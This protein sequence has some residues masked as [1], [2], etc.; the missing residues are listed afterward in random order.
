MRIGR[1]RAAVTGDDRRKESLSG[2]G[3]P[4]GR[5]GGRTTRKPEDLP[6]TGLVWLSRS[7]PSGSVWC[8]S[9]DQS[10]PGARVARTGVFC[11]PLASG[12][13]VSHVA[14]TSR[15]CP[16]TNPRQLPMTPVC[17]LAASSIRVQATWSIERHNDVRPHDCCSIKK[18]GTDGLGP[19]APLTEKTWCTSPREAILTRVPR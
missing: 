17:A 6:A 1:G 13:D 3:C 15:W 9:P 5:R 12:G 2:C 10:T 11:W 7:G 18:R 14:L 8:F 19:P 16:F 4:M